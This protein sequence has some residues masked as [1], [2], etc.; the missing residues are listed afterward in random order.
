MRGVFDWVNRPA[1]RR[2]R[3]SGSA[4]VWG[5]LGAAAAL[6]VGSLLLYWRSGYS[7]TMLVLWLAALVALS[8]VFWS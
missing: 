4:L 8:A 1:L 7:R 3:V 6:G 5:L 2:A